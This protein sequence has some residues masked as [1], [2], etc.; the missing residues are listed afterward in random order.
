M[1]VAA[2]TVSFVLP[3]TVPEVAV[4]VVLPAETEVARPLEPAV[5][6]TAATAVL[7]EFQVTD[8]VISWL[9]LSEKIPLAVNCLVVPS[10]MLGLVGET[11]METSVAV[12]TVS[13]VLPEIM[14]EV[15][16]TVVEPAETEVANPFV[17]ALLMVAMVPLDD[18][19]VTEAVRSW[20]VLS[21]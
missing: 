19:Q 14:P 15:A 16:V 9:V 17:P 8:E 11:W 13:V 7:D 21:E 1:S 6:L 10:S 20:V 3:E 4:I 2:V 18:V 5:L 12:V